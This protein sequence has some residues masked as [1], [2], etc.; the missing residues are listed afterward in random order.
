VTSITNTADIR[1]GSG[2]E[3]SQGA[4]KAV[5][6]LADLARNTSTETWAD[7]RTGAEL[8]GRAQ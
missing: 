5:F 1:P 7:A 3:M 2:A 6:A 4:A 8:L